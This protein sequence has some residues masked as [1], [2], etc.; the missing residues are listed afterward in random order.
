[1]WIP[2]QDASSAISSHQLFSASGQSGLREYQ[3]FRREGVLLVDREQ[4]SQLGWL[5]RREGADKGS[6]RLTL[7]GGVHRGRQ[8]CVKL[9][10]DRTALFPGVLAEKL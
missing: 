6:Q 3:R 9:P 4:W 5:Q 2:V 7:Q 1:M 10:D 8:T